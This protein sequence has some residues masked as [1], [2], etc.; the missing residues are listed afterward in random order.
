M[1]KLSKYLPR[2]KFLQPALCSVKFDRN[3][4]T[5]DSLIESELEAQETSAR[6]SCFITFN[7]TST[8]V[9][10]RPEN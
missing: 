1:P 9:P 7:T 6:I 5:A 3:P 2:L 8:Y 10:G 4:D